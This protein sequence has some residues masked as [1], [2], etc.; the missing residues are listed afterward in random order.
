MASISENRKL[1]VENMKKVRTQL[2]EASGKNIGSNLIKLH[3][4]WN[5]EIKKIQ[6][7]E[8]WSLSKLGKMD[9]KSLLKLLRFEM[10]DKYAKKYLGI[11]NGNKVRIKYAFGDVTGTI[12]KLQASVDTSG[13]R[14]KT[15]TAKFMGYY[16]QFKDDVVDNALESTGK[17][18][19]RF[20]HPGIG[21][22]RLII[23]PHFDGKELYI[24]KV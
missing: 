8:H 15:P 1:M 6:G 7:G 14:H 18:S 5:A 2:S 16:I 3:A 21:K 13:G 22:N 19:G 24:D 9:R 17:K 4:D 11:K 12:D 10:G 20:N 23:E